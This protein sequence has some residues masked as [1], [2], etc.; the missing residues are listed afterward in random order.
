[1][2]DYINRVLAGDPGVLA[3]AAAVAGAAL[4]VLLFAVRLTRM[5]PRSKEI[6]PAS[7]ARDSELTAAATGTSSAASAAP[8]REIV[9]DFRNEGIVAWRHVYNAQT[10]I[11][12]IDN[13]VYQVG[14]NHNALSRAH[15]IA[16]RGRAY[17]VHFRVAALAD[18]T[19]GGKNNFFV[20]PMY[21]DVEGKVVG[22]YREQPP[23]S[24]AEGE[25]TG[26]VDS[27]PPANAATVHIG[28]MGNYAKEGQAGDGVI[29][30]SEL[31]L[32]EV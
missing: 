13:G 15:L 3:P 7:S 32:V 24:V 27:V 26:T 11:G 12:V 31:R 17:R 14:R 4:L 10:A 25:R 9:A 19:N 28:V 23:I 22:W 6:E 30:F 20:G 8:G 5:T 16:S 1:M 2:G 18:S 21:L 29:A